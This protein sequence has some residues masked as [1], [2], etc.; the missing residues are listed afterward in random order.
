MSQPV[1]VW[2]M[3]GVV[4]SDKAALKTLFRRLEVS[5]ASAASGGAGAFHEVLWGTCAVRM[6]GKLP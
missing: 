5:S 3:G 4:S 1:A 2:G 6:E